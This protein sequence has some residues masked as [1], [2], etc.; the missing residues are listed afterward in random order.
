[1]AS[2]G[3]LLSCVSELLNW[4]VD[5]NIRGGRYFLPLVAASSEGHEAVVRLLLE[6]EADVDAK[7][8]DGGTA[9]YWA[10]RH[11]HEAVVNLIQSHRTAPYLNC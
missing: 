10:A 3:G 8:T 6:H 7:D 2:E 1:M 5:V 4:G 11:G 9:L